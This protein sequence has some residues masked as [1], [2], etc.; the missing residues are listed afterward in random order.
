MKKEKLKN[1]GFFGVFDFA[2]KLMDKK[3]KCIFIFMI[4]AYSLLGIILLIPAQVTA[5]MVSIIA[6]EPAT[7]LGFEIP[8]HLPLV[9]LIIVCA[10]L[11]LLPQV[12]V[13]VIG[14]FRNKF[15]QRIYIKAKEK[16]FDWA[17]TPRKNLEL[18][19][20]IG[21]AT[22]RINNSIS[23]L[24]YTLT[25]FLDC[26]LPSIILA[27]SSAVYVITE[28][29]LAMPVLFM[30]LVLVTIVFLLRQK[31]ELPITKNLEKQ[32][33]RLTNFLVNTLG[34]LHLINISKSRKLEQENLEDRTND[35][36]NAHKKVFKI[37]SVYWLINN[38]ITV[39]STYA[40]ILICSN[41]LSSGLISA[42]A[43]VLILSYV[44]NV[45]APVQ[46]FGWFINQST[47]LMA[48]IT[49]LEELKP[50]KENTIDVSQDDYSKPIEK[51]ELKNV[52]VVNDNE[53]IVD[54]INYTLNKGELTIITGES[55]G[56]KT[57]S[58]RA[59]I[60]IAE[61]DNGE[62]ILNDEYKAHSMYSFIDRMA[63]VLQSPF[64]F[65]RDVIDNVYY[66]N[67]AKSTK[68]KQIISDLHMD[69]IIKKKFNEENEQE[70]ELKLS[71]GEKKRICVLRGLLQEK[72]I[73]VFDE[74]TNELDAENTEIVLNYINQL[75]EKA[76]VMV[77]THDKR[78]IDRADKIVTINNAIKK[79]I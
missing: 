30:G 27:I 9:V 7:L 71:G 60:G 1:K 64:I 70:M 32:C 4:F 11:Q 19:M 75:K 14:Y 67:I 39:V 50:T 45:F 72:E 8:N 53:T 43:I 15:A 65:N 52:K 63:V 79:E 68:S 66:P 16:A 3:E 55:G 5:I 51:I 31:I 35:Y 22:Y 59:L 29:F 28:E 73:Y 17:T 6:K 21:D 18:G 33:S 25:N 10:L 57:T 78:M 69:K 26:I 62:I 76:I 36:K 40:I 12:F 37:W 24:E 47:Q 77:V 61:I 74:P 20:T 38:I 54:N 13:N 34:N 46:D 2:W 49:R 58:L 23:D 41:R 44:A 56:G 48:K 42:S